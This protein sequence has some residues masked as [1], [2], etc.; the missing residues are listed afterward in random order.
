MIFP[1]ELIDVLKKANAAKDIANI[2]KTIKATE[3]LIRA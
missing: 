3:A 1:V 2:Q